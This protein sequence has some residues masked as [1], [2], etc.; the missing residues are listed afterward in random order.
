VTLSEAAISAVTN[1]ANLSSFAP[2]GQVLAVNDQKAIDEL[3]TTA[4]I[5]GDEAR[6]AARKAVLAIGGS[7]EKRQK[8]GGLATG[9]MRVHHFDVWWV[10]KSAV[11]DRTE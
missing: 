8:R 7:V 11:G 4:G 9:R 10:P 5:D 2:P 1:R 6:A 3:C